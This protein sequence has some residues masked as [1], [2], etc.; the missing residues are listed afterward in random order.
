MITKGQFA[1][2]DDETGFNAFQLRMYDARIG[3]WI[4]PD[5]YK[6]FAS[7]YV[8]MGNNPIS[9]ID[10][11]GGYIY[12]LGNSNN[13]LDYISLLDKTKIGKDLINKYIN[14]PHQH[15]YIK[16]GDLSG[17][18][19]H[20]S[21]AFTYTTN[22]YS[23]I[24]NKD[25]QTKFKF[26]G[27]NPD[28]QEMAKIFNGESI[29][30]ANTEFWKAESVSFIAIDPNKNSNVL[31]G[32]DALAHEIAAHTTLGVDGHSNMDVWGTPYYTLQ[33]SH[34]NNKSQ[35]YKFNKELT[36]YANNPNV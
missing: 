14:N 15:L 10:V 27:S 1:E 5:P 21:G 2:K 8:G 36:K 12:I 32:V 35:A 17:I 22:Y 26:S 28:I 13:I 7:A 31:Y 9:A 20:N 4:R 6:Q 23:D 11:D 16:E 30:E 34:L 25:N 18:A 24:V 33:D 3:R 29:P 19:N